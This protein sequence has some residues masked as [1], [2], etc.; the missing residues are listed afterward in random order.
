MVVTA[1][2]LSPISLKTT[3]PA[4]CIRP[5]AKFVFR[6]ASTMASGSI[7]DVAAAAPDATRWFQLYVQADLR[8]A[9]GLVERAAA[10]GYPEFVS[11]V[12]PPERFRYSSATF[13]VRGFLKFAHGR[14]LM[15]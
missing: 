7:E 12:L 11:K 9:P 15:T 14:L 5:P 6:I 13:W 1:L 10:A 8:R 2:G 4:Y 3:G